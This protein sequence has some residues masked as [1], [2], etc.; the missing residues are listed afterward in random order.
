MIN[1]RLARE[2]FGDET[3]VGKVI[4]EER[5]PNEPPPEPERE[6]R[7]SSASSAWSTTS[8]RTASCR[9]RENYLFY[10]MRLDSPDPEGGAARA[11]LRPPGAG[12]PGGVRG[13]ARQAGDGGCR[14]PGRSRSSRSTPCAPTSCASTPIPLMV[15]GTIAGFLLLMVGLGLTGVVWQSV[16]QRIREFGLRRAKG[17]TIPQRPRAGPDR[18]DDH[19]LA[20]AHRRG[21]AGRAAAA[22]AAA[23]GHARRSRR[24]SSSPASSISVL[25]IYALTLLCGWQPSRLATRIQPAEA[26]HYE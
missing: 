16:T 5:D 7:R 2:I 1:R 3:A 9:R 15:V 10:R 4:Q 12:H 21:R 18:D 20:R 19:D 24:R 17:A 11:N 25:A 14:Q 6:A 23:R 22:A 8:A 13:D 26:L